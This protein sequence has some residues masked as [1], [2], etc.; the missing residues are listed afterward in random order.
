MARM[1]IEV[2]AARAEKHGVSLGD[3]AVAYLPHYAPL[4]SR[5]P[6]LANL[7]NAWPAAKALEPLLGFSAARKLPAWRRTAPLAPEEGPADGKPVVLFADTFNRYFE[8]EN[9]KAACAVLAAAGYRIKHAV[10]AEGGRP[11]CCGRTFLSAGLVDKARAELRRTLDALEPHLERGTPIVGLEPSCLLTFRDELQAL[12]PDERSNQLAKQT[13]LFE[14]FIAAEA[15][16]GAF[17]L[18]FEAQAKEVHL[19][20][21]CHQKSFAAMHAVE[22]T[23]KLV[24][25]LT[26][27]SIESSCCGMAGAFG[28]KSATAAISKAMAELSLFP[29]VRAAPA[30]A[31]IAADG[32]SCRSQIRDGTGREAVHVAR[33]LA[34]ALP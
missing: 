1:K 16:R 12:L 11:L 18:A 3:L 28:Y 23:L 33:I 19:H 8:P 17:H 27:K 7:R 5:V 26:V 24:P 30:N 10:P 25:S 22:R 32:F 31:A 2:L 29:A 34:D 20:G 6:F 14:E 21:H 4:F 9:L 13:F 15:A